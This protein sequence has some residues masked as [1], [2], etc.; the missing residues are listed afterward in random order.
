[1]AVHHSFIKAVTIVKRIGSGL[2]LLS[3]IVPRI[4]IK[5]VRDIAGSPFFGMEKHSDKK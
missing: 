3:S 1:M 5:V 2:V 4:Y